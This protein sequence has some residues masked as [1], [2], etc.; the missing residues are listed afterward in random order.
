MDVALITG[1]IGGALSLIDD[2]LTYTNGKKVRDLGNRDFYLP[3]KSI[4]LKPLWKKF[5]LEKG[6]LIG[7]I[8]K[9]VFFFIA[10]YWAAN[11]LS[12]EVLFPKLIL[13]KATGICLSTQ[14]WVILLDRI[15]ITITFPLLLC[16]IAR[17]AIIRHIK[18]MFWSDEQW[19]RYMKALRR[20][21][22]LLKEKSNS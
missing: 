10:F 9:T 7:I 2:V 8:P 14:N 21:D 16:I 6:S 18:I 20:Q 15:A 1:L 4:L 22:K 13:C 3:E 12:S 11:D 17:Y 5:G 19:Q